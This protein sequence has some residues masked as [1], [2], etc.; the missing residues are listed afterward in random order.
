SPPVLPEHRF[1]LLQDCLCGPLV[2]LAVSRDG[3]P[4]SVDM[5]LRV[6]PA[7]GFGDSA[8][9][10]VSF[11]VDAFHQVSTFHSIRLSPSSRKCLEVYRHIVSRPA[12]RSATAAHSQ[13]PSR[14]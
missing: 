4:C 9:A 10:A 7:F 14:R 3:D 11:A 5:E 6:F 8:A 13:A 12:W 1:A 2:D